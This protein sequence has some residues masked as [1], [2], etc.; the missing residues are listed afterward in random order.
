MFALLLEITP[1]RGPVA[2]IRPSDCFIVLG[3]LKFFSINNCISKWRLGARSFHYWQPAPRCRMLSCL[4]RGSKE[5]VMLEDLIPCKATPIVN[6]IAVKADNTSQ[7]KSTW[8]LVHAHN[9]NK[10]TSMF[11]VSVLLLM[12]S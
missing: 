10:L 5:G 6:S 3:Q 8:I 7:S 4:K 12:I 2:K 1:V 9:Q 11:F